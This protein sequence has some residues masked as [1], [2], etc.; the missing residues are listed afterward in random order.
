M[1]EKIF[2]EKQLKK[3]LIESVNDPLTGDIIGAV[4]INNQNKV[5]KIIELDEI[6]Q[7]I[8]SPE[9]Q[10]LLD[11]ES[12]VNGKTLEPL[13]AH[14]QAVENAKNN[15]NGSGEENGNGGENNNS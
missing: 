15:N 9:D 1:E 12:K 6:K 8:I 4:K 14:K 7:P 3:T 11:Q 5:E 2:K 13:D 10:R